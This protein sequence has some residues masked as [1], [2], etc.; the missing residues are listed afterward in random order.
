MRTKKKAFTVSR[1]DGDSMI[2]INVVMGIGNIVIKY[3]ALMVMHLNKKD[4]FIGEYEI[5]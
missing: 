1:R 3:T 2:S 5:C 4:L